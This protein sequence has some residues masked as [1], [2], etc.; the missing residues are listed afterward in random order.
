MQALSTARQL[1][2]ASWW[3]GIM[4][5]VVSGFGGAIGSFVGVETVLDVGLRKTILVMVV[6]AGFSAAVSLGKF[7]QTHSVPDA[8]P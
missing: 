6:T 8:K 4:G 2:W 3:L 7:L 5:A 1:D